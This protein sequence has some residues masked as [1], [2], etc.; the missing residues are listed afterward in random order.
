MSAP[1]SAALGAPAGPVIAGLGLALSV[2]DP[3]RPAAKPSREINRPGRA[4]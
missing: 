1:R 4:F 3:A 2:L